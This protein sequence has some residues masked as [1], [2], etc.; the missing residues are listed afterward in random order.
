MK[1]DIDIIIPVKDRQE[2]LLNALDSINS[3]KLLPEKVIIVDDCSK[4]R[5]FINKAYNFKVKI[6]RNKIN[7]GVSFSRNKGVRNSRNKYVSFL[8]SDDTWIKDKLKFQH[9]LLMKYN[10]DF[11]S[12]DLIFLE[13]KYENSK[14]NLLKKF[15]L[16]N[17]FPNPSSIIFKRKVFLKIGGFDEKLK[18]CE[19]N[20]IW[21][22]ILSSKFKILSTI[23]RK[24]IINKLRREASASLFFYTI[25]FL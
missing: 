18:T 17:S 6:L 20:D 8:D 21:I 4:K 3:Q 12:T 11:L 1:R 19:D 14:I 23:E 25:S 22:K 7:K 9:K 15:L 13:K 2:L 5:I 24:V 10:L 16:L